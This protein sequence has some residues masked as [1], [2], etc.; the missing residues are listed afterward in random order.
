MNIR[1][2]RNISSP[3]AKIEYISYFM[4]TIKL[5]GGHQEADAVVTVLILGLIGL[6]R[7]SADLLVE[8]KYIKAF[9]PEDLHDKVAE[10]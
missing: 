3:T 8:L 10:C 7:K 5:E 1:N 9:S 6:G 4:D 2:V